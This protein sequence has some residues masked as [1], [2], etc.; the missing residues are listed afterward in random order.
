MKK[1]YLFL[2]F[3]IALA[4]NAKADYYIVGSFENNN[5]KFNVAQ[6]TLTLLEKLGNA[7][8]DHASAYPRYQLE[9]GMYAEID[10]EMKVAIG[11]TPIYCD[12]VQPGY[13]KIIFNTKNMTLKFETI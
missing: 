3:A 10:T 2:A 4:I 5:W 1:I 8:T 6:Y 9:D 13:Y 12:K 11:N 7:E